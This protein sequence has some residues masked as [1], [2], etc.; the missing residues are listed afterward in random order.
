MHQK[1]P[2]IDFKFTTKDLS[3]FVKQRSDAH[4]ASFLFYFYCKAHPN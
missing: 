3:N 4:F 1:I 2:E